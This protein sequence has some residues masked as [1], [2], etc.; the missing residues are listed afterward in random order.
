MAVSSLG[1]MDVSCC[2]LGPTIQPKGDLQ[3]QFYIRVPDSTPDSFEVNIN[4]QSGGFQ[5]DLYY[6]GDDYHSP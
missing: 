6:H 5:Y 1:E 4:A 3:V 2:Q